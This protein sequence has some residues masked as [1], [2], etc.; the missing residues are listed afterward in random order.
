MNPNVLNQCVNILTGVYGEAVVKGSR[1]E[2]I[3][4]ALSSLKNNDAIILCEQII[5][6]QRN[7]P[8]PDEVTKFVYEFKRQFRIRHGK[9]YDDLDIINAQYTKIDC[10][11]CYDTGI[12]KIEHHGK[13]DF[14]HLIRC[15]C[16]KGILNNSKMPIWDSSLSAAFVKKALNDK[17]FNPGI[18]EN[19]NDKSVESKIMK[20]VNEWKSQIKRSENYWSDLGY[21]TKGETNAI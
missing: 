19:E 10:E 14:Q 21:K 5:K 4:S 15:S 16:E 9:H 8:L 13:N 12:V 2:A 1:L 11:F 20:K 3:S 17:W 18:T 6:T 7:Y